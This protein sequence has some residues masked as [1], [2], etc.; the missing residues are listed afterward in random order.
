[1]AIISSGKAGKA[2]VLRL[3]IYI[4]ICLWFPGQWRLIPVHWQW[5]KRSIRQ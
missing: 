2:L 3:P 5:W 4:Y 1:M